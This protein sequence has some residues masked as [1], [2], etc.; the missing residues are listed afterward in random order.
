MEVS[1]AA[2]GQDRIFSILEQKVTREVEFSEKL[3]KMNLE[4]KMQAEKMAMAEALIL[5]F[6]A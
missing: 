1:A 3:A 4:L 2:G 5:D 6:Y